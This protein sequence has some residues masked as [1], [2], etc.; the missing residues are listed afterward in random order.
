MSPSSPRSLA[1][2]LAATT[3]L[4]PRFAVNAR[5]LDLDP[6]RRFFIPRAAVKKPG[7]SPFFT[8]DDDG[9]TEQDTR[10]PELLRVL[11]ACGLTSRR[12]PASGRDQR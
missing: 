8:D 1:R 12:D 6:G 5:H 2:S 4:T 10:A 11:R 3:A 7:F 9:E